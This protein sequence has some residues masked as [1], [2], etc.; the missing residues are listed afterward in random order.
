M[1]CATGAADFSETDDGRIDQRYFGAQSFR[2]TCFVGDRTGEAHPG[3]RSSTK[4]NRPACRT[5]RTYSS[6]VS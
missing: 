2:R 5:A 1:S 3:A 6:R 4:L